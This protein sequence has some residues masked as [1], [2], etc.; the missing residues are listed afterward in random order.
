MAGM[1]LVVVVGL[2]FWGPFPQAPM[3]TPTPA[4]SEG[5]VFVPA[6]EFVMGSDDARSRRF[7]RGRPLLQRRDRASEHGRDVREPQSNEDEKPMRVVYLDA[8]YIDRHEVTNAEYAEFLNVMGGHQGRCGGHDCIDTKDQD[9]DSHI[10]YRGGGYMVEGG[11]VVEAG[12]ERHPVIKVSWYGAKAYCEYYGKRLPTE[13]EWEKAARGP[14]GFVYPWGDEF[15]ANKA[16]VDQHV[17]DTTPVGNYRGGISPYGAYDMAGNVWEWVADWY[18]AYPGSE[19]R[20][21]F[22][23]SKYKVVRGGSWNHPP[24]DARGAVRDIAHPAR[25][26]HVVGFRC[27]Q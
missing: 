10:L 14:T 21:E 4:F 12:Y 1:A 18:R 5:M 13:A 7:E 11:Y 26:I 17:G 27:A 2:V 20:S 16:N 3:P 23:G 8:F 6:G 24:G 15:D 19:H 9:P 25:R 22:F